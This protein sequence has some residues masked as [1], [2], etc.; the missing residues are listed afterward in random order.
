MQL[1]YLVFLQH[2]DNLDPV[3]KLFLE[4]ENFNIND[5]SN[6]KNNF[7]V[8][9]K[10][11]KKVLELVGKYCNENFAYPLFWFQ[12][13]I[14]SYL[15]DDID[16]QKKTLTNNQITTLKDKFNCSLF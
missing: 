15:I 11:E 16:P 9:S 12:P 7:F 5:F 8:K 3:V 6:S 2:L 1:L 4:S 14:I 10:L 13:Y